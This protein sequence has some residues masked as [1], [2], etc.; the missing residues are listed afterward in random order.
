M[1][2]PEAPDLGLSLDREELGTPG[3]SAHAQTCQVD[4]HVAL[5]QR[6]TDV[7]HRRSRQLHVHGAPRPPAPDPDELRGADLSSA[8]LE[9]AILCGA[10]LHG[11]DLRGTK[12]T[13]GDLRRADLSD[14]DLR[15]GVLCDAD[16]EDANLAGADLGSTLVYD[17]KNLTVEQLRSTKSLWLTELHS[18]MRLAEELA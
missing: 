14:V 1:R 17:A 12:F 10:D 7:Q 3:E 18:R 4:R 13:S 5:R 8:D 16:L 6:G 2:V 9:R 15:S 11:A